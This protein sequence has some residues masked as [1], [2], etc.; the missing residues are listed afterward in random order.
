MKSKEKTYLFFETEVSGLPFRRGEKRRGLTSLLRV[1]WAVYN[2][3]G[4]MIDVQDRLVFHAA[5]L[6][7][8]TVKVTGL[9]TRFLQMHGK[10]K[11][12]VIDEF[13][14]VLASASHVISYNLNFELGMLENE[15]GDFTVSLALRGTKRTCLMRE[16]KVASVAGKVK[17]THYLS[18]EELYF[19]KF[20]EECNLK[21]TPY[22][23]VA[24][25]ARCF[26]QSG[27]KF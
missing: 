2:E 4:H 17:R 22:S 7:P 21:R 1:T 24:I 19:T 27:S 9:T 13:L 15:I 8:Q 14:E 23:E 5:Q 10:E 20:G 26:F 18:L 12:K 3:H 16:A 11:V 6:K 25:M